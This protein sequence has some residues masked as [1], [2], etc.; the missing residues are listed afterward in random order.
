MRC[1][2]SIDRASQ[3][4]TPQDPVKIEPPKKWVPIENL[5]NYSAS[6]T[7]LA[8]VSPGT[9]LAGVASSHV[10]SYHSI[11]EATHSPETRIRMPADRLLELKLFHHFGLIYSPNGPE[12]TS[13]E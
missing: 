3:P 4:S 12:R 9:K 5:P 7:A 6:S 11:S 13:S 1:D 2:F 8:H 10:A